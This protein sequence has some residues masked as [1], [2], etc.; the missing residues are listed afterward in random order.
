MTNRFRWLV[1]LVS[2]VFALSYAVSALAWHAPHIEARCTRDGEIRWLVTTT[3]QDEGDLTITGLP[4]GDVTINHSGTVQQ[5]TGAVQGVP[6][7]TY[8]LTVTWDNDNGSSD[9]TTAECRERETPTPAATPVT[10]TSTPITPTS[11]AVPPTATTVPPTNTPA[12]PTS[13]TTPPTGTVV[14]PTSTVAPPTATSVPPISTSPIQE[15]PTRR[16]VAPPPPTS[17]PSTAT[18]QATPGRIRKDDDDGKRG[19]GKTPNGGRTQCDKSK[20]YRDRL[21]AEAQRTG[22]LVDWDH[23]R[24]FGP[25]NPPTSAPIVSVPTATNIPPTPTEDAVEEVFE[26]ELPEFTP[27]VDN[28]PYLNP[29]EEMNTPETVEIPTDWT[30]GGVA[31]VQFPTH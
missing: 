19:N 4:G 1:A 20:E 6:G 30:P 31:P 9:S 22:R 16:D 5:S 25:S 8:H 13:T 28:P 29:E 26:E 27:A 17:V 2:V 3:G 7:T 18:P 10:P 21:W 24:L 23:C 14:P 15:T 11:T 12:T